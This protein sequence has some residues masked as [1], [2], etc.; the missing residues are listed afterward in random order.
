MSP[1]EVK[2]SLFGDEKRWVQLKPNNWAEF[3]SLIEDLMGKN[4]EVRRDFI[5]ENVDFEN[6]KFL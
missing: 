4:V 2:E 1:Q 6:I 3:S 5:F